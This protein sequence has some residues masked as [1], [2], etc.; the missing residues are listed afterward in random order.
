MLLESGKK[1]TVR[2]SAITTGNVVRKLPALGAR[3]LLLSLHMVSG[4]PPHM[5]QA[6][7]DFAASL[8]HIAALTLPHNISVH[9]RHNLKLPL[10]P[11]AK[12]SLAPSALQPTTVR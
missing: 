10:G 2:A 3:D 4:A 1:L 8:R 6:S 9:L 11:G 7:D 5:T 12:T